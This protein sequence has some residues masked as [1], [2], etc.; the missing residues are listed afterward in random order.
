MTVDPAKAPVKPDLN[1]VN[2][3]VTGTLYTFKLATHWFRKQKDR[4][5]CF[6]MTGSLNAWI[7]SPVGIDQRAPLP[8]TRSSHEG[9][10]TGS[11]ASQSMPS[12]V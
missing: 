2:T 3:N 10:A 12:V 11:M 7:D 1:I 5:G 8:M 9:R 4:G 6:I